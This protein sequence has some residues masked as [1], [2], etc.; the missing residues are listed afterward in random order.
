MIDGEGAPVGEAAE[1]AFVLLNEVPYVRN[2]ARAEDAAT[3]LRA[4]LA[5]CGL[6]DRVA[7][8]RADVTVAGIGMVELGRVTPAV[9]ELLAELL[10][11]A[12]RPGASATGSE[13]RAA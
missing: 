13:Q 6:E 3:R 8:V 5:A 10:S 11:I 2:W 12:R 1:P 7:G 9:A 4:E